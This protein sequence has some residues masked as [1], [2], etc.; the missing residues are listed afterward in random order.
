[1]KMM[2]LIGAGVSFA[3]A[4]DAMGYAVKGF[5][6]LQAWPTSSEIVEEYANTDV[7]RI[8][9]AATQIRIRQIKEGIQQFCIPEGAV[10]EIQSLPKFK[11]NNEFSRQYKQCHL[12]TRHS[13]A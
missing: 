6:S 11:S 3:I 12:C 1:M 10:V 9:H 2:K 13:G 8:E 5:V 7:K 4:A